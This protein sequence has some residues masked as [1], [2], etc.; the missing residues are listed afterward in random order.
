MQFS[1]PIYRLKRQAKHDAKAR[2]VP[3]HE[4]LDAAARAEGYRG[5]GH[6]SAMANA[7][8]ADGVF[9][10]LRPGDLVLL[11]A[12]PG[13]GKT[14]LALE[15]ALAAERR[16][17][18]AAF[19]TLEY[20]AADVAARLQDLGVDPKQTTLSVDTSDKI[21]ADYI[22]AHVRAADKPAFAVIDYLQ[23]LDQRR[24]TPPLGI[25]LQALKACAA[26]EEAVIVAI[27]QIDR[28]F[29]LSADPLPTLADV[30]LP[31]PADLSVFTK[32]CFL[33]NGVVS[34]AD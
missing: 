9:R 30:R 33:H 34:T 11:G 21:C 16:G 12:R 7:S 1:A 23:L 28:S 25:Q 22:A 32:T 2:G 13:H 31:N 14:L 29:E 5:W 8:P 10:A 26:E 15:L 20:T 6:L 17:H 3:L 27:S 24:T 18:D 19:F 4:A